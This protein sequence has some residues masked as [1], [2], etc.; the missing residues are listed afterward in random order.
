ML[1]VVSSRTAISP[2]YRNSKIFSSILLLSLKK[3]LAP[4]RSVAVLGCMPPSGPAASGSKL[5]VR[6][7]ME[8]KLRGSVG[9]ATGTVAVCTD[10]VAPSAELT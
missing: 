4:R 6:D 2:R 8:R 3:M 10:S 9:C 5:A 1:V 7:D